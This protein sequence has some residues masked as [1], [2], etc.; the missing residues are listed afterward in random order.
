MKL[1]FPL[2]LFAS[3]V[4]FAA[5]SAA[6]FA[7][8]AVAV[9]GTVTN[10]TTG[11]PSAGDTVAL[12]AP[13]LQMKQVAHA[14]TDAKGRYSLS[15][16]QSGMYLVR[17]EHQGASYFQP[18]PPGAGT[19]DVKVFNVAAVVKGVTTEAN[20]I[21]METSGG[22]LN[23]IQSFFVKNASSP[24]ITQ[25]GEHS[26]ELYLPAG[27]QIDESAAM[28]PDGMPIKSPLVPVGKDGRYAY[29]F[30]VRPGETQFQITYH[31]PYSGSLSLT[32]R[33]AAPASDF[34]VMVP[35]TMKFEAQ[36]G[37][38]FAAV[39]QPAGAVTYVVRNAAVHDKLGFTVS[40]SGSLPQAVQGSAQS[41]QEGNPSAGDVND[42]P[43][44]GLGKPIDT[45]YP[46]SKYKWWILG[47]LV[48]MFA[49]AAGLLLRRPAPAVASGPAVAAAAPLPVA[50]RA[51]EATL[52]DRLNDEMFAIETDR[53]TG[54][55]SEPEYA[56]LKAA[57]EL[58]MRRAQTEDR[59]PA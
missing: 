2:R 24:P 25:G 44:I 15:A 50:A 19:V 41:A 51:P 57:L 59:Q 32:P 26:Y 20:V 23:V 7:A 45:P 55:L 1:T 58:L 54:K 39:N 3:V 5:F 48:L 17:V 8:S 36:P 42:R 12:I 31:L 30:P 9:T 40:G 56:E 34:L 33:L 43:G 37:A 35:N 28:G 18:A 38:S 14:M 47:S 21:R 10:E 11:R 27:A 53:A 52:L 49:I 29:S 13:A 22:V 16:A 46:L 4:L 6:A